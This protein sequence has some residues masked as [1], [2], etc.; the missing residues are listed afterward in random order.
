M[1]S[2][3]H[4]QWVR[5]LSKNNVCP[6]SVQVVETNRRLW[7][8]RIL[9]TRPPHE[10]IVDRKTELPPQK[11]QSE[12]LLTKGGS[13]PISCPGS[14]SGALSRDS[15]RDIWLFVCLFACLLVW[16][17]HHNEAKARPG[18]RGTATPT[19][20]SRAARALQKSQ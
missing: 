13:V 4:S 17:L 12:P 3:D 9:E 18:G 20:K 6:Q 8:L 16:L 14:G 1:S 10:W 2:S 11:R 15:S 19:P 5:A 7:K